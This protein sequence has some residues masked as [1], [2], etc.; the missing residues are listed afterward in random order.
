M[1]Y[2]SK[3]LPVGSG[4][5]EELRESGSEERGERGY[6]YDQFKG[7]IWYEVND[8]LEGLPE[9]PSEETIRD[10]VLPAALAETHWVNRRTAIEILQMAYMRPKHT[11]WIFHEH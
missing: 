10:F 4:S 2:T 3:G 1:K 11:N 5:E 9:Y 8:A 7:K 6:L